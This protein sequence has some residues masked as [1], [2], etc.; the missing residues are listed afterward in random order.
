LIP[1]D[2]NNDQAITLTKKIFVWPT[3]CYNLKGKQALDIKTMISLILSTISK[4]ISH[5]FPPVPT[6]APTPKK[7]TI[8]NKVDSEVENYQLLV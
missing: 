7:P 4:S 6:P 3:G 8:Y 5:V 1:L 2:N